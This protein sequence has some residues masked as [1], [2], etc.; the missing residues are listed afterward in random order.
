MFRNLL[1]NRKTIGG[2]KSL[3]K[4]N[5]YI[6]H[7]KSFI[8][9]VININNKGAILIEF[10]FTIP[11]LLV[12]ILYIYDINKFS[13]IKNCIKTATYYG[14]NII[15]NISQNRTNKKLTK[16]DFINLSRTLILSLPISQAMIQNKYK[17]QLYIIT[18]MTLIEGITN[19]KCK[20]KWSIFTDFNEGQITKY[21]S[22]NNA[23]TDI[24]GTWAS[25]LNYRYGCTAKI[26]QEIISTTLFHDLHIKKGEIKAILEISFYNNHTGRTKNI[27]ELLETKLLKLPSLKGL[28]DT[29]FNTHVIFSPKAGIFDISTPPK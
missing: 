2:G 9:I 4:S 11:L 25:V 5:S 14:V 26:N 12:I 23:N 6:I 3:C 21:V 8:Q 13:Y 27:E 24:T 10:A 20:V 29:Y 16:N 19:D 7:L 15:Q 1:S 28:G 18:T 22:N 17:S